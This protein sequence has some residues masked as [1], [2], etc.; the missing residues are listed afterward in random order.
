ML[1]SISVEAQELQVVNVDSSLFPNIKMGIIYKGKTKFQQDE[2]NVFQD[3]RKIPYTLQESAPGSAPGKG[4]TVYFLIESSGNTYG[5][6]IT[7]IKDG[8]KAA[9]TP[10]FITEMPFP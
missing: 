10:S 6:G 8:V 1:N 2:L 7:I 5:K 4:R 9:L 3:E